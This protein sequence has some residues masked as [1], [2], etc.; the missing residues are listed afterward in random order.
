M[1]A[2]LVEVIPAVPEQEPILCNLLEL[3]AHDFSEFRHLELGTDGRFGYGPLPLYWSDPNRH[4]F[5]I[6]VD[7]QLAGFALVKRGSE[8]SDAAAVWDI[9][10]FFV[11]R[12]YRR[13]GIGTEIA[14]DVWKR[15]PGLWE[16]RVMQSNHPA[17]HFWQRAIQM[18]TGEKARSI[19]IEKGGQSWLVFSFESK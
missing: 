1:S 10:E 9:V 17:V 5:L 11:V 6:K 15:F 12:A 3:Y 13:H 14:C 7:G 19:E 8:I 4:P 16:I 18:F 2:G